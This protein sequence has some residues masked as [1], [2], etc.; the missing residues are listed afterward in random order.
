M[1]TTMT[2]T[3]IIAMIYTRLIIFHSSSAISIS[4][5]GFYSF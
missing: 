2:V 4:S 1:E 3:I 5:Y